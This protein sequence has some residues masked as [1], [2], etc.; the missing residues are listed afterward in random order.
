MKNL[1]AL[2]E[3]KILKPGAKLLPIGYK[4]LAAEL[5][6]E[7]NICLDNHRFQDINDAMAHVLKDAAETSSNG[8]Q[9]WSWYS[10]ERKLWLPLEHARA[11]WESQ[12]SGAEDKVKTSVTDPIRIDY[13]TPINSQGR[14]GMTLCPG[15]KGSGLYGG[16]WD[17]DLLSDLK[18][19][20]M[21]GAEV[22]V[23]LMETHEFA[24]LGIP[25]FFDVIN[26]T[27]LTWFHCPIKDMNPPGKAFELAWQTCHTNLKDHLNSGR[28]IVF[29]CRGGLGR[30]GMIAARLLAEMGESPVAAIKRVRASRDR[31]IETYAQEHYVL[32]QNW[33]SL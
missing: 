12:Q 13:I 18:Q 24:H 1:K 14:I 23:S 21:W 3:A 9:F 27:N 17:R 16:S 11:Q 25:N 29:H 30:T 28:S 31:A 20:E 19:I 10:D 26:Q 32:T 15:K 22:L 33:K 7:G 4:D 5:D 8:L 2:I 6:A